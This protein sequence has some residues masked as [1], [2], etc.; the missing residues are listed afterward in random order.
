MRG[1]MPQQAHAACVEFDQ[2]LMLMRGGNLGPPYTIWHP[3]LTYL[4]SMQNQ[5]G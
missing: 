1:C 5:Q 2:Q 3:A 4:V